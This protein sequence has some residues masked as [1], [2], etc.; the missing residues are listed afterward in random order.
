MPSVT[1]AVFAQ[2]NNS[3]KSPRFSGLKLHKMSATTHVPAFIPNT[4]RVTLQLKAFEWILNADFTMRKLA[5][6]FPV[7]GMPSQNRKLCDRRDKSIL[8]ILAFIKL[9]QGQIIGYF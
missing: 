7:I 8:L 9:S 1:F 2:W 4:P 5:I 3:I 6:K